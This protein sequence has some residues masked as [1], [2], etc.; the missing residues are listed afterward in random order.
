M[1]SVRIQVQSNEGDLEVTETLPARAFGGETEEELISR[2]L[3]IAIGK[4]DRAFG[5]SQRRGNEA[6]KPVGGAE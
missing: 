5:L 1:T 4:V 6:P 3:Q 2:L